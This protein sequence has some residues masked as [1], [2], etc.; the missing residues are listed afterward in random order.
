MDS[1]PR[2]PDNDKSMAI[3]L[4][5]RIAATLE[6][7]EKQQDEYFAVDLTARYPFGKP[8]DRWRRRA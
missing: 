4:L 6:R 5:E 3:A 2:K 7:L 1:I 8:M